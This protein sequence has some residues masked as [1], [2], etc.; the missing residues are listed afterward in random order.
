[1]SPEGYIKRMIEGY[2]RYFGEDPPTKANINSPLEKNDHPEMDTSEFL[3]EREVNIYQSLMGSLQWA[4][5]IGRL[6]I[7]TAVMSMSSFRALP[8]RGHLERVKRLIGYLSKFRHFK[9]RFRTEEPDYSTL[10]NVQHEWDYTVYGNKKEILPVD[11]PTPLGK[12]VTTTRWF[13]ANLLHDML[14]G[15]AVSDVIH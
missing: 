1:M 4:V 12:R 13:N 14:P 6:D 5:S 9:I 2:N 15:K 3:E 10:S 7:T 11:V 8:R